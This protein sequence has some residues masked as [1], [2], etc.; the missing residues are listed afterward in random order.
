MKFL[1]LGLVAL[2][3]QV[4]LRFPADEKQ[5]LRFKRKSSLVPSTDVS[6]F[7][8]FFF[9]VQKFKHS[10]TG[11]CTQ[12]SERW[13]DEVRVSTREGM[14]PSEHLGAK[15]NNPIAAVSGY[16]QALDSLNYL[17]VVARRGQGCLPLSVCLRASVSSITACC[18]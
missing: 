8:H 7:H 10:F 3:D 18:C 15:I 14:G 4:C 5:R 12:M 6:H 16:P 11:K 17:S 13:W 1:P 2:E 9:S